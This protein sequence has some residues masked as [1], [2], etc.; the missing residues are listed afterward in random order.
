MTLK[1]KVIY[2]A[3]SVVIGILTVLTVIFAL[4]GTGVIGGDKATL[5]FSSATETFV[6]DGNEHVAKEWKMLEG[7]L[8]EGHTANVI[9]NGKR[10]DVGEST[11][12]LTAVILDKKGADVSSY[13]EISYE[14]GT[15]KV[16][17]REIAVK[18]NDGEKTYDGTPLTVDGYKI[19]SGTI[20]EGQKLDC[21]VTGSITDAGTTDNVFVVTIT[22]SNG[23]DKTSNYEIKP[24]YGKLKVVP[25]VI[26]ISTPTLFYSYNGKDIKI[27]STDESLGYEIVSTVTVLD[28]DEIFIKK[29]ITVKNV[30]EYP[31]TLSEIIVKDR[32]TGK[33]VSYNYDFKIIEGVIKVLPRKLTVQSGNAE[34]DYDGTDLTCAEWNIVSDTQPVEGHTVKVVISGRRLSPGESP[35]YIAEVLVYDENGNDVT[36]C[37]NIEKKE[38]S[39]VV[40][41]ETNGD[42]GGS[43]GESGGGS[44]SGSGSLGGNSFGKPDA[45]ARDEVMLIIT[46]PYTD[47]I[48]LRYKSFGD[49]T[50]RGWADAEEYTGNIDGYSLNY[51]L[52]LLCKE[53]LAGYEIDIRNLTNDY[54]LPY[55]MTYTGS[56]QLQTSDVIYKG[57]TADNYTVYYIPES[58]VSVVLSRISASKTKYKSVEEAYRAFV[59]EKYLSVPS[60]TKTYLSSLITKNGFDKDDTEILSKVARY[61][62]N[63][64][65][66][67]LDYND[68]LDKQQDVVV[69]FLSDYKEGICQ[70]FA[71]AGTM[72]FRALGIPARY[73]IGY[74]GSVK[75]DTPS[76]IK[77]SSAHAWVEVYLDGKGWQ[78]V[79]VTGG[80]SGSG[81]PVAG[82]NEDGETKIRL[83]VRPATSYK[84]YNFGLPLT[85]DNKVTGLE[86]LLKKNPDYTYIAEIEGQLC[87]VGKCTTT[88][89]SLRIFNELGEDITEK[90]DIIKETGLLHVYFSKLTLKTAS[91]EKVYDGTPVTAVGDATVTGSL[92]A[93]HRYEIIYGNNV[94]VNVGITENTATLRVLDESGNDVTDM[95]L[96]VNDFGKL[97]VTPLEIS[98]KAN[99]V[100]MQYQEG[101]ELKDDGYTFVTGA[102]VDGHTIEVTISGSISA[103]G[104]CDNVI[105]RVKITD[106]NGNDVTKN[107]SIK[108]YN[109]ILQ[110]TR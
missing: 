44:G 64:A 63:A 56:Y 8:K 85:P 52:S 36:H 54:L 96:L 106:A 39:L 26:T 30:G 110:L 47:T 78:K 76:E 95:Y 81:S 41:G 90:F 31:N 66:Y 1:S 15:I 77:A 100:A 22:D 71:S 17:P 92:I 84:Q 49:Y 55:Y 89:K 104:K 45:D 14:P 99:S 69:S 94:H 24:L 32:E 107:Y 87:E 42:G 16:D 65:N 97:T 105:V 4:I 27:E 68:A 61:I 98:I 50:G 72:M 53:K 60:S 43:G 29:E 23:N 13:Y 7:K 9:V 109:G 10:T 3:G 62:Q 46:S 86:E 25:L 38:G 67:N 70:H 6:Y 103:V 73:V 37:Y 5:I 93:G 40:K 19:E 18:T 34:K 59:Y 82:D 28:K 101:I 20:V 57:P 33:I 11:N 80:S 108:T 83:K 79:E 35:N 58:K 102:L 51:L 74:V 91:A 21:K 12:F 48:Y 75:A 2:I 88:I